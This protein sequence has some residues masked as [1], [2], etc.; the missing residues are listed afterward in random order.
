[1]NMAEP[2]PLPGIINDPHTYSL[3]K[4]TPLWRVHPS[5]YAE[6]EFNPGKGNARFSP[7]MDAKGNQIPTIYA[8]SDIGAAIMETVYHDVPFGQ[9]VKTYDRSRFNGSVISCITS[10]R[11]LC[12]AKLF[13]PATRNYP[14][15][16]GGLT[17]SDA[18]H[19]PST[20]EWAIALHACVMS[21]GAQLD[22]LIWMS[23][24]HSGQQALM[25]FGDRVSASDLQIIQ[26]LS[27]ITMHPDA[28]V[29][30][31]E[32]AAEMGVVLLD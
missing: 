24:Q 13:G 2:F 25:L 10:T 27:P 14:S 5:Q 15:E 3:K 21:Q 32:L 8:G 11:D 26:P 18:I 20:R 23:R 30:L 12:L 22:G 9:G 31:E 7:I 4:G 29:L 1:M 16:Y 28:S 19:Y 17:Q 6:R